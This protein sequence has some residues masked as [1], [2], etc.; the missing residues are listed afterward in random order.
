MDAISVPQSTIEVIGRLAIATLLGAGI[1]INREREGKPAGLR[2]NALVSL[3]GALFT[4]I[5]LLLSPGDPSA[6]ARVLQGVT[7][8]IGF[9]GAGVI[10]RRPD[11]HDVQ[12]LTTAAAIW[13]VSAI[14][15]A[16]GAGL[17]RTSLIAL[18]LGLSF[19]LLMLVFRSVLVPLKA[20]IMNLLSV[21]AAYGLLVFVF[22]RGLG[23]RVFDFT[24]TGAVNWVTPVFLFAILFGLSMDYEVFLISRIRELHDRGYSNEEAVAAFLD[25]RLDFLGIAPVVEATLEAYEDDGS[26]DLQAVLAAED[27][28]RR[29]ARTLIAGRQSA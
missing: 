11:L 3:G 13:L 15:V 19:I 17:W 22:Q 29:H 23:E 6:T 25:G 28:A 4:V 26:S 8:G 16:V 7:A 2:T 12:G 20:V 1:G 14:G 24:S 5:A 21:L 10:M 27:W 18:V 9:I